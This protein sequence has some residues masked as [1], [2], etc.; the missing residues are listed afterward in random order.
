MKYTPRFEL[1]NKTM[2]WNYRIKW[3][4]RANPHDNGRYWQYEENWY[5]LAGIDARLFGY[6]GFHYDQHRLT[7]ITIL[8]IVFGKGYSHQDERIL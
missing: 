3:Y 2:C 5:V 6:E 7:T 4:A 8:G 1:Q